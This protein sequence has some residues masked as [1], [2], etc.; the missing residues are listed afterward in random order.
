[1]SCHLDR[2]ATRNE[3]SSFYAIC[4]NFK[5][6]RLVLGDLRSESAE[7]MARQPRR[8]RMRL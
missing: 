8:G 6:K 4:S 5:F 1:M 7:E 2:S 3:M